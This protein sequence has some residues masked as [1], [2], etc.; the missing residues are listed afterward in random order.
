MVKRIVDSNVDQERAKRDPSEGPI[1]SGM[2]ETADWIPDVGHPIQSDVLSPAAED[3]WSAEQDRKLGSVE[4]G[5]NE[6][7]RRSEGSK[8]LQTDAAR[9][10]PNRSAASTE[11]RPEHAQQSGGWGD[12]P[13]AHPY[14]SENANRERTAYRWSTR[15]ATEGTAE[16]NLYEQDFRRDYDA[17][18]SNSG[19]T[20][21]NYVLA[22]RFGYD[23]A[24]DQHY[25]GRTWDEIV[26]DV[27]RDWE[28][29]YP[30]MPWDRLR[31]AVRHG[32]EFTSKAASFSN[33]SA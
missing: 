17:N 20:Y 7:I 5:D 26:P 19:W 16:W 8:V 10:K 23:F 27:R 31:A 13:N 21:D 30:G 2:E 11:G 24:R 18:Y 3:S 33:R 15:A 28:T 32:W 4:D 12:D 9:I 1:A 14:D 22:Y 29:N 25:R 6:P